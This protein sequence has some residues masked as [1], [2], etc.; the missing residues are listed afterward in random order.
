MSD[1]HYVNDTF[2]VTAE[3]YG[4]DG[5]TPVTPLSATADIINQ[6]TGATVLSNQGC[7]VGLGTATYQVPTA[8]SAN[9]GKYLAYITVVFDAQN[10]QTI[11]IIFHVLDKKSNLAVEMWRRKVRDSATSESAMSDEDARDWIDD[12]VALING[13]YDTGYTSVLGVITPTP[14]LNDLELI[15]TVASLMARTAWHAGKGNWKDTEMS[16]DTRPFKEEWDRLD[17]VLNTVF[18]ESLFISADMYNRD[19]TDVDYLIYESESYYSYP[20]L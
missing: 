18:G 7:L 11:P 17:R 5:E 20:V 15:A 8:V 3:V 12:A 6:V 2:P 9:A 19:H 14:T 1:P 4:A 10:K 13:K 16:I